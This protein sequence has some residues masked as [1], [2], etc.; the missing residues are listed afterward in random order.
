MVMDV[1]LLQAM[2]S[3]N[4]PSTTTEDFAFRTYITV[5]LGNGLNWKWR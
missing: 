2:T 5:D 4:R 3:A 1:T